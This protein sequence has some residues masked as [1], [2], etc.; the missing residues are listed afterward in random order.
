V[1]LPTPAEALIIITMSR[2]AFLSFI[3]ILALTGCG[4]APDEPAFEGPLTPM[5]RAEIMEPSDTVLAAAI[6]QYLDIANGPANT[7]Y[8]FTRVDLDGDTRRDALVMMKGPHNY[9]CGMDG[10]SLVVFKAADDH[11]T[12]VSEIFPVRGPMYVSNR[13]S[14]EGWRNLVVHVSGQSYARAK[15][16]ALKFDGSG[17]PRNPFF[18]PEIIISQ[19]DQGQRLFP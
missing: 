5:P 19:A 15:D 8:D 7:L 10:C 9:W 3:T 18:E 11:F 14:D 17:Y 12:M 13:I 16:V 1:Q 4:T 6:T 2:S